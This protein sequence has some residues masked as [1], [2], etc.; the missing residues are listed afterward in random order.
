MMTLLIIEDEIKTARQLKRNVER[1]LPDAIVLDMLQSVKSS[2]KWL[3]ENAAPDLILC[4]IQLAD[5]L[6]FEIF[7]Q[8]NVVSPIVFC[9]AFDEYAIDA[10]RTS[11]IDY[12]LKPVD[13][14]KL[15]QALD[16]YQKLKSVFTEDGISPVTGGLLLNYHAQ[17]KKT[18]L[19][20]YQEKIIPLKVADVAFMHYEFGNVNLFTFDRKK[21]VMPQ[22]LDEFESQLS[23]AEFFRV[24]RQFIV[25]RS[26][27]ETISNYF[28]RRLLLKL[29]I[30]V[31]EEIVVSK[32]KS[33]QFLK[34]IGND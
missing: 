29:I 9:T 12:L 30:A 10:F 6:S 17:Y 20:H 8:V 4:D 18:L 14:A 31:P 5:G 21:Y 13:E 3:Q 23:P 32:T 22:T 26:S 7:R 1:I 27:V 25:N 24:N 19:V 16:K 11:G 28:S 15:Q 2:V 34:W 33:P